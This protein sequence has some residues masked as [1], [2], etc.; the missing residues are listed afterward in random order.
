MASHCTFVSFKLNLVLLESLL[1]GLHNNATITDKDIFI[2]C[3]SIVKV[4][5]LK[6]FKFMA[7]KAFLLVI[8]TSLHSIDNNDSNCIKF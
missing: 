7:N 4:S 8:M 5:V 3:Q 6:F 1:S 2:C